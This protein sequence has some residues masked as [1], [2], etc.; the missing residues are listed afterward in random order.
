[1]VGKNATT[2]GASL[3]GKDIAKAV[4]GFIRAPSLSPTARRL[5]VELVG[6]ANKHTFRCDPSEA[7]LAHLLGVSVRAIG[8]AKKQLQD[9]GLL[10][11]RTA[12]QNGT[13]NYHI[14]WKALARIGDEKLETW[15]QTQEEQISQ[16]HGTPV[17]VRHER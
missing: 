16:P 17:P 8:K 15:K 7:R 4:V 14:S 10:T 2:N 11:W 5:G 12:G 6:H 13:C 1:M 3:S 9:K